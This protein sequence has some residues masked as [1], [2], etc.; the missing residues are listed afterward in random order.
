MGAFG[1][2]SGLAS[3]WS[4]G[5]GKF[6]GKSELSGLVWLRDCLNG[7]RDLGGVITQD[8]VS[9]ADYYYKS[10]NDCWGWQIYIMK[11]WAYLSTQPILSILVYLRFIVS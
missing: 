1:C 11:I 6:L 10:R 8:G 4:L 7:G 5:L 3:I 2:I 9:F